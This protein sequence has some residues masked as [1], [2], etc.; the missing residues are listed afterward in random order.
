MKDVLLNSTIAIRENM[1]YPEFLDR[2]RQ[3]VTIIVKDYYEELF[4]MYKEVE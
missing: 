3:M 2:I 1:T 4:A